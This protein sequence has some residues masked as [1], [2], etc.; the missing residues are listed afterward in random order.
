MAGQS[1]IPP[2]GQKQAASPVDSLQAAKGRE[3][4]PPAI[5]IAL[6][7]DGGK[8][9]A[10]QVVAKGSGEV[11]EQILQL[12]FDHGV[13]VRSDADLATILSAVEVE[14]EVPLEALTAVANIL[15][16]IYRSEQ[17]LS[18]EPPLSSENSS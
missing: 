2:R 6:Q 10:T 5:A 1:D 16:Y 12:A 4:D 11:A 14:S 13:K 17:P 8:A 9:Q 18:G 3:T 15:S 7:S